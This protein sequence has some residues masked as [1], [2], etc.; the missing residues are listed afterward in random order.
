MTQ[1]IIIDEEG[2]IEFVYSDDLAEA[3]GLDELVGAGL[4]T[5][6]RASHVEPAAG[7]GWNVDM[8]PRGGPASLGVF[9]KRAD[10][11]AAEVEWLKQQMVSQERCK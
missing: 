2:R 6:E 8:T 10:A 9:T 5:V 7:G 4:A 11:L 3:M 1:D